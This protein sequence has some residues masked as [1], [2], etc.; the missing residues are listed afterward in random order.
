MKW[1]ARAKSLLQRHH[2]DSFILLLFVI[3]AIALLVFLKLASEVREGE[4]FAFDRWLLLALRVPSDPSVPIGPNWLRH[5]MVDFTSLGGTPIL[6]LITT[7]ATGYLLV[8]KRAETAIFL[9]LA[10]AGGALTSTLLKLFFA[11]ARPDI[12]HHL[13]D[14]TN[15]SFPS[16]HAMNSAVTYLTLG[17][18]LARTEKQRSIRVY[19]ISLAIFLTLTIGFSRVYLGVHWPSDVAAGW[20]L[21]GV[22]ALFCS[23]V[24][25]TLQRRR[26]IEPEG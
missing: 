14:V 15:A 21:G 18:L 13:V 19:L 8:A 17:A 12:V 9:V 22:W 3:G 25:R 1:I 24:A 11:R 4:S 26:M 5:T 10:V 7:A 23:L 2:A 6:A 16:G 20:C